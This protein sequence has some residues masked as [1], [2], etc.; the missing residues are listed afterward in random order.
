M[1]YGITLVAEN[2]RRELNVSIKKIADQVTEGLNMEKK[3]WS[4]L[5]S[6]E[7]EVDRNLNEIDEVVEKTVSLI[8]V[9]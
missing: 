4:D 2:M 9:L 8:L 1:T 5:H 6:F 7:C 3:A